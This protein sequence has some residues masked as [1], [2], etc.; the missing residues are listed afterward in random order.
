MH[1]INS[2]AQSVLIDGSGSGISTTTRDNGTGGSINISAQSL[3]VQNGGTLTA[4]TSGTD[5]SATGGVITVNANT[6]TL[7]TGGT[8]TAA[9]T[10]AGAAGDITVQGLASPANSVL[11]DGSGSGIFTNTSSTGAGGN[12]VVNGN[13]VALQN[14]SH[15]SSS[16]TGA[17]IA[18]N[19]R[20]TP[21]TSWR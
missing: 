14:G 1:G 12:I 3:T 4:A 5:S 7:T 15:I 10:G 20:S 8:M 2:P 21:A 11:I 9:S 18:G 19:V 17:G 13:S 6:I 16:S